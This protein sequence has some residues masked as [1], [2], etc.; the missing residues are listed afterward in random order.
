MGDIDFLSLPDVLLAHADQ[1]TRYG[2]DPG[3]RD[4]G[5]LESAIAQPQ[6][7]FGGTFLHEFPFEMAARICSVSCRIIPFSTATSDRCC[8]RPR[9]QVGTRSVL[10]ESCRH[11]L[12]RRDV[13]RLSSRE[14]LPA[15]DDHI[16]IQRVEFHQER[17]VVAPCREVW[18]P[19]VR[20]LLCRSQHCLSR[21]RWR[22][23]AQKP[24]CGRINSPASRQHAWLPQD[25]PA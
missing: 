6:S 11:S 5:L 15:L 24:E 22:S 10:S 23:T 20:V 4:V 16:A 7:T 19:N 12:S 8:Q 14:L 13:F 3:V 9:W 17:R 18:N 1:I 25:G 2:G 21:L